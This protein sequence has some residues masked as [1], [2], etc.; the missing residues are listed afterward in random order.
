MMDHKAYKLDLIYG[1]HLIFV[2]FLFS[3]CL[4]F[5]SQARMEY[6][7]LGNPSGAQLRIS[8]LIMGTDHLGKIPHDQAVAVLNEAV[9][10]GINMF[11]TAPIY[12]NSIEDQLG[13]WL[14]AQNRDDLYVITKGGF[15][16]DIGPGS[17]ESRLKGSKDRI[18]SNVKEE[19]EGSF[20]R[21][22][23]HISIYLMHRDDLDFLNYNKINRPFT[24]ARNI[25]EA[26]SH[27]DIKSKF[28]MLGLSNW[29]PERIEEARNAAHEN[30]Q[31]VMPVVSSPYFSILEMSS[32]TIHSGGVQVYH[33]EMMDPEFQKGIKMMTYSPLGGFSIFS[34]TWAE[35][36]AHA[37]DLRDQGDRYWGHV[38]ESLFH[39]SNEAR[40]R[41][42]NEFTDG[43][44]LL[45]KSNYTPDQVANAYVLAHPRADFLIIGPRTLDQL[46]RTVSA[47]E[48]SKMLTQDDLDFLYDNS[49]TPEFRK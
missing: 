5:T 12:V 17:Y 19:I 48:L 37:R 34:K 4:P 41:R 45:H 23:G 32:V 22:N 35:A 33:R 25:L 10:Q 1:K 46:K 24:P 15:P 7:S 2:F 9:A 16:F 36:K 39:A 11:D 44:N 26:L 31:L 18:V 20:Q 8:R 6:Q 3:T 47:L 29:L 38:Y 21:L 27:P 13:R 40:F 14:K 43:F 49:K 30:A 42:V 28:M